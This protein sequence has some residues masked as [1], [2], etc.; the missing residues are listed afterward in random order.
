MNLF[1][2]DYAKRKNEEVEKLCYMDANSLKVYIKIE[3]IYGD[4]A[5]DVK[6]KV[7]TSNF[8]LER[9]LPKKKKE[10]GNWINGE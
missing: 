8:E 7:D 10:K 4:I 5:K 1:S 3:D 2:Y 9:P 6:T